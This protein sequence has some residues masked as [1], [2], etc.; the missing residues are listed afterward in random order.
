MDT[1]YLCCI[2]LGNIAKVRTF[3]TLRC[4]HRFHSKCIQKWVI[5]KKKCPICNSDDTSCQH[6]TH[7]KSVT[8]CML[9]VYKDI[10]EKQEVLIEQ[11]QDELNRPVQFIIN[12]EDNESNGMF[13]INEEMNRI[14]YS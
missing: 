6:E 11:L 8:D 9:S 4:G 12:F 2:C 3:C 1:P 7:S 14:I 10:T 13:D 5:Y